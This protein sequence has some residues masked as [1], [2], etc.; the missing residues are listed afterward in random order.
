MLDCLIGDVRMLFQMKSRAFAMSVFFCSKFRNYFFLHV[1]P[2]IQA[3]LSFPFCSMRVLE[4]L[5]NCASLSFIAFANSKD[6][7]EPV[8]KRN[9]RMFC[10]N[11]QS[12][13]VHVDRGSSQ[14]LQF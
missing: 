12:M 9:Q 11:L 13:E 2:Y 7:D 1:T 6:S 8:L 5:E 4:P 3:R 10:Y 14:T